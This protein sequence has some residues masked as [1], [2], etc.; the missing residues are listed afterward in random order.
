[1]RLAVMLVP[2]PIGSFKS[3]DSSLD[4]AVAFAVM[5]VFD[6][7]VLP[8]VFVGVAPSYAFNVKPKDGGGDAGSQIDLLLRVG[9]AYALNE[10]LG[11][12]GYASPGYSIVKPPEGDSA[13]GLVVGLHAGAMFDIAT[14]LFLAGEVGYQLGFQKVNDVEAKTNY[15][16]IGLGVGM[17]I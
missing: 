8:N 1:M 5:P 15:L 9:G 6:Y 3:G 13:K 2:M 14:K 12:Y 16:Q 10:K 4:S 17:R 11:L 7:L